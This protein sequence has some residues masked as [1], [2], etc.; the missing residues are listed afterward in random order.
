MKGI[1]NFLKMTI[2]ILLLGIIIISCDNETTTDTK[3]YADVSITVKNSS[4]NNIIGYKFGYS[5]IDGNWQGV[6]DS[7]NTNY[8]ESISPVIEPEN[9][10]SEISFRIYNSM[11]GKYKF[12]VSVRTEA[13]TN[14]IY[15]YDST[16]KPSNNLKLKL[17]VNGSGSDFYDWTLE[18]DE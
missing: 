10:F 3:Q 9:T 13:M 17:S 8:H 11:D 2:L 5:D 14:I 7:L 4:N 16:T 1:G 12:Y 15:S 6:F 18:M